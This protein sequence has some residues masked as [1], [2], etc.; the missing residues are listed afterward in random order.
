MA[1][2]SEGQQNTTVA[3]P[4]RLQLAVAVLVM[5]GYAL[6]IVLLVQ[7]RGDD[8]WD[9]LVYLFSGFE[10]IVFAAAGMVFGTTVQRDQ[11]HTARQEAAAAKEEAARNAQDAHHLQAL[12]MLI[13]AKMG[14]DDQQAPD[15]TVNSDVAELA[16]VVRAIRD[17]RV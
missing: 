15:S 2:D 8:H 4:S 5:V 3:G 14:T 13:E 11:L 17:A 7:R 16:A 12:S 6:F 1:G 9:R 10:A